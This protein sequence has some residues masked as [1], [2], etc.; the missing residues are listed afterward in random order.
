MD[1]GERE[2]YLGGLRVGEEGF[3]GAAVL[4]VDAAASS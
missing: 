4:H 3:E 1:G 2:G